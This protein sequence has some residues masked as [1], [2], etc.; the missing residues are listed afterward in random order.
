MDKA[1]RPIKRLTTLLTSGNLWLYILSLI[2]KEGELYAYALDERIEKDFSFRPNKIMVYIVLYKLEGEGLIASKF[3]ER[4]KY[5]KLT[6]EG[7]K[8]LQRAREY[9][10]T[11]SE[12][13]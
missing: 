8:T 7:R 4:R 11:L 2:S 10:K 1:P 3:V 5:Y 9:F 6:D 12:R 13:L